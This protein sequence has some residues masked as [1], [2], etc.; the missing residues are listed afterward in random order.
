MPLEGNR[1]KRSYGTKVEDYPQ[2]VPDRGGRSR[3]HRTWPRC[4]GAGCHMRSRLETEFDL[5]GFSVLVRLSDQG[6]IASDLVVEAR[7]FPRVTS[8]RR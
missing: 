8:S 1:A 6:G 7:R 4:L 5:E 2:E 3:A